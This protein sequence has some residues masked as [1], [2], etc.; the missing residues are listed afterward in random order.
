MIG[1]AYIGCPTV[2]DDIALISDNPEDLQHA[3]YFV[4]NETQKDK[5]TIN[6]S[7]NE[8][9]LVNSNRNR[10]PQKWTMG[11]MQIVE[12]QSKKHIGLIRQSE[13]NITYPTD[14]ER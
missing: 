4:Q 11:N 12:V 6:A 5:V 2:A 8:V 7:K 14:P 3:L 13:G 1:T 10:E 9:V